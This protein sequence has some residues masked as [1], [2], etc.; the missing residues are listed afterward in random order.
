VVVPGNSERAIIGGVRKELPMSMMD[1]ELAP[2]EAGELFDV[3]QAQQMFGMLSRSVRRHL[4][5]ALLTFLAISS[6]AVMLGY[7]TPKQ[8]LSY[9]VMQLKPTKVTGEL[10]APGEPRSSQDPREGVRESVLQQKNLELIVDELQLVQEIKANTSPIGKLLQKIRPPVEDPIA[11][12][13]DAVDQLR[14]SIEVEVP[15][16]D[17]NFETIITSTWT[18]PVT[19]TNIAKKLQDNFIADRRL[20]EVTQIE[21][22]VVIL[23]EDAERAQGLLDEVN[24]RIGTAGA[25]EIAAADQGILSAAQAKQASSE[26]T[27]E[28]GQLTLRAAKID[29]ETRYSVSQEPQI[30]KRALN[31]RMKSYIL[32]VGAGI[33]GGVLIAALADLSK[34]AF[35]E[36]WQI[37][38]KLSLP[39]LAE[40]PE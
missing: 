3:R 28:K 40:I 8:Y 24:N 5:R 23:K 21:T 2:G 19:A 34:G 30:P 14:E 29:F 39:V 4:T 25:L 16:G 6:A 26:A 11:D 9:S 33:V 15:T 37:S 1:R 20:N 27:Y 7:S 18:N 12:R 31:G 35:V 10:I 32:G 22:I 17:G 13:R 36:S 38:R